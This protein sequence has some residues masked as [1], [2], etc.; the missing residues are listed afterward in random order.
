MRGEACELLAPAGDERS[1]LCAL[2]GGADAIY[3]GLE[4]LNAR[5]NAANFSEEAFERSCNLAHLL[6][7]RVYL[8]LNVAIKDVELAKAVHVAERGT[9]L[10]ADA[11]IVQDLGLLSALHDAHPSLELHVST[12]ANVHDARGV[13][14]CKRH[15]ASRVTLSRELSL[16]EIGECCAAGAQAGIGCE[17]FCHGALCVSYS[18]LCLMSSL[19]GKR[20]A[21]RGFCAQPCRLP[22]QLFDGSGSPRAPKETRALCPKDLSATAE[23]GKLLSAGVCSLKIEG[24]MKGPDYVL[25][26]TRAWREALDALDIPDGSDTPKASLSSTSDGLPTLAPEV[27]SRIDRALK[28]SFNRDFTTAYLH[29]RSGPEMMS[30]T[31]SNNRGT[32]VGKVVASSGKRVR[33]ALDDAVGEGDLLEL[34]PLKDPDRF[35]TLKSPRAANAGECLA[36]ELKRP[37]PVGVPVRLLRERAA[38]LAVRAV[39][40]APFPRYRPVDLSARAAL[41]EPLS[42]RVALDS[43]TLEERAAYGDVVEV[44]ATGPLVERARTK[45]LTTDELVEHIS[46]L[47]AT[48]FVARFAKGELSDGVGLSFS[49]IHQ[50]RVGA[51]RKLESALLAPYASRSARLAQESSTRP[52]EARRG[53][54][55]E[56]SSAFEQNERFEAPKKIELCCLVASAEVAWAAREAG[57]DRLYGALDAFFGNADLPDALIPWLDEVCREA[58]HDRIDPLIGS[59]APCVV[60]NV[61][62]LALAQERNA[63][64]EVG[65][66]LPVFNGATAA[67]LEACGA[68]GLW[69]SPE[70]SIEEMSA[71]V[72][73]TSLACGV[74]VAGALRAMTT[75]HC[76]LQCDEACERARVRDSRAALG[77]G[78]ACALCARNKGRPFLENIDGRHLPLTSAHGRSRVWWDE[79]LDLV[80]FLN[81]LASLGARRYLIDARLM[82]ASE[83][84][85]EI[86]RLRRALSGALPRPRPHSTTAHLFDPIQ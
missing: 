57:V 46:R 41:G 24:R 78:D 62:E 43:R 49:T 52:K 9:I 80:P 69:L 16:K 75:E 81:R 8:T 83:V 50:V 56:A 15:G 6:G 65:F 17:V 14:W 2:A 85:C 64:F 45:E 3:C 28:R 82:T 72:F 37:M 61:S 32:L 33:V 20:S 5:Q 18:G 31:R 12:Q 19:R 71:V 44:E 11:L 22:H 23:L 35:L 4:T 34:R 86:K 73:S 79:A 48:P 47:G 36:L 59:G 40:K 13:L 67:L 55:R 29:G 68:R 76:V 38:T 84:T 51:V 30:P 58:D 26:V 53:A 66:D 54:F 7:V 42:L 25:L 60:A 74:V 63:T 77:A 39:L 70:L 1:F 27:Q 21:N 10:G